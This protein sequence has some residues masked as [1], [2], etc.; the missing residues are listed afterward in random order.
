MKKVI[1]LSESD[2][3]RVI[4]RI[5]KEQSEP[6]TA[7][8]SGP[9]PGPQSGGTEEFSVED[10]Q[11]QASAEGITGDVSQYV[12]KQ[13]PVCAPPQTGDAEKDGIINKIFAW[14]NKQT[15]QTL[16]SELKNLRQKLKQARQEKKEG[17]L[18]EQMAPIIIAGVS[19]AP[20]ILIAIG[21]FLIIIIIA[22]IVKKTGKK[23]K[24]CKSGFW[25][26]LNQ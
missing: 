9:T 7:L 18:Q 14:A 15:P 24:Y 11:A 23:G 5:V 13:S 1:R 19:I 22:A 26:N 16:R 2:L 21:V 10:L 20:G 8:G 17:R 4:K 12:N 25:D 6:N 3:I